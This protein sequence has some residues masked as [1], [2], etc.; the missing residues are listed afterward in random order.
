MSTLQLVTRWGNRP[1]VEPAQIAV[2]MTIKNSEGSRM[3]EKPIPGRP[4]KSARPPLDVDTLMPQ[5]GGHIAVELSRRIAARKRKA[6]ERRLK[7]ARSD[8]PY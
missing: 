7:R 6:A 2:L 1:I 8:S 5:L 4:A 3:R